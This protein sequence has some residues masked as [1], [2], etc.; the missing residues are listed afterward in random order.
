M[1]AGANDTGETVKLTVVVD[2]YAF[3]A[4]LRTGWGF[5]AWLESRHIEGD[6]QRT[7][8]FD[9]GGKGSLLLRN[10]AA[11]DL[12][13][14]IIDIVILSHNH[15][16]HT[17]G[18]PAVLAAN[19]NITVYLPQ[20]FPNRFE[21]RIQAT[22]ATVAQVGDPM[23]ISPGLWTT[24]QMGTGPVEQ[25]LVARTEH[26][27]LV[28]TGCAHPGVDRIVARSK[29]IGRDDIALVVGGFHLGGA[30]RR[31]VAQIIS[32][33]RRLGV[34][35]IAPCHCTGDRG[36]QIFHQAYG[37]NFFPSGVGWQWRS[38]PPE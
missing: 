26:G 3:D 6:T 36:R 11:L 15:G 32:E 29:E 18:L 19:P 21:K 5:A 20:A 7:V 33:F 16:D 2:N 28:V 14:Q 37:E 31:R 22:G 35:Q 25:A 17:G 30:S 34:Q 24:G 13:P 23:E 27:L 12:D 38:E 9:T 1:Y 10:M 4:R 8:L